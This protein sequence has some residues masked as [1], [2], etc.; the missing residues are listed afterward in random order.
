M[1]VSPGIVPHLS[2]PNGG[3]QSGLSV[4]VAG[5]PIISSWTNMSPTACQIDKSRRVPTL[6]PLKGSNNFEGRIPIFFA[7]KNWE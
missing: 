1:N 4:D 2:K 3:V 5:R 7:T 6:P